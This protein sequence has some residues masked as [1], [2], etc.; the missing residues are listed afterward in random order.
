[1]KGGIFYIAEAFSKANNKYTQSYDVNKPSKFI[2]YLDANNINGWAISQ[3][4][5]MVDLN[6]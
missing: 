3:C 6:G 2:T 5:H 4:F 1:M